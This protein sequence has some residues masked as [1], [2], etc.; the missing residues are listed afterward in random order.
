MWGKQDFNKQ[1]VNIPLVA[2][3]DSSEKSFPNDVRQ[4]IPTGYKKGKYKGVSVLVGGKVLHESSIDQIDFDFSIVE[5][6]LMR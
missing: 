2:I 5:E 6:K 4:D 3:S 1:K